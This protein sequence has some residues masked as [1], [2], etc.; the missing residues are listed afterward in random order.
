MP[1]H[2]AATTPAST[3]AAPG[4]DLTGIVLQDVA[5]DSDVAAALIAELQQEYVVRYGGPD[6]T[7][8]DTDDACCARWRTAPAA[9]A[10]DA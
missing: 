2:H 1:Q 10:I 8:V 3:A 6:A 5:H 7:A 4:D 9:W